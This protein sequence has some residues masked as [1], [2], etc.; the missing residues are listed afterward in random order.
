MYLA[1]KS[2]FFADV[3][4]CMHTPKANNDYSHG[5]KPE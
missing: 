1:L 2:L 4:M 5:M 3:D